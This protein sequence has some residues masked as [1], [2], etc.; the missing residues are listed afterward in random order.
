MSGSNSSSSPA[1]TAGINVTSFSIV[2]GASNP[3]TQKPYNPSPLN[4]AVGTTV[5]WINNYI[6]A[7]TVT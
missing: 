7:H 6:T 2:K 5:S 1:A 4:V 3:S